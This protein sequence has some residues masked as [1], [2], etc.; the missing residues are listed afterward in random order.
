MATITRGQTFGTAEQI[1][2]T[3][4]H[5]LVD[6]A[7]ITGI[8]NSE[9][10]SNLLTS[11]ASS[12]GKIPPQ[13]LWEYKSVA[14]NSSVPSISTGTVFKLNSSTYACIASFSGMRTGQVFTLIAGQASYPGICD[15]G[16]FLLSANWIAAKAGD[17]LTLIWDGT[18]F[19]EISRVAT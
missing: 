1:T 10:S 15:T 3:K 18:S 16:S 9:L 7:T 2:N 19:I 12:S 14:T 8:T 4:L 6:L 5:N 13:N 17:N 11:L